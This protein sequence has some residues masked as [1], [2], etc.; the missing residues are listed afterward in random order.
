M[1]DLI[2]Y[3]G[4]IYTLAGKECVSALAVTG[5]RIEA[6]GNDREVLALADDRTRCI[7]LKGK[8][9]LPGFTDT[10]CHA[11]YAGLAKRQIPLNGVRSVEEIIQRGRDFIEKYQVPEGTWLVAGGFDHNHFD[12]PRLPQAADLDRI[13]TRH[14]I[15]LERIC[16]H[17]G[18]INTLAL[19]QTGFDREITFE[20]G[21][22]VEKDAQGRPTGVIVET[23]L[24]LI[25]TRIPKP[26]KYT[27]KE[28]FRAAFEEAN[29]YGVTGMHT[30][31]VPG[32]SLQTV[33]DALKDLEEEGRMTVRVWEEVE[34]P[35]IPELKEFLATGLRTGSGNRFFKIGNIKLISDGSLGART[36][37]LQAPYSDDPE[38]CG[39]RVYTQEELDEVV[40]TAHEAGMQVACHAIGDGAIQ[41]CAAALQRAY[42]S[43][44]KDLRNRIVH[45][46]F[47]NEKILDTMAAGR[48]CADIQPAFL[49]SDLPI[50]HERMGERDQ[51]GYAWKSLADKNLILGGGS[52]CPVETFNP[53]WG[54]HCAVNRTDAGGQPEGGWHPQQKLTV[55]EAVRLYTTGGAKLSLE[56]DCK[57]TLEP[58]KFADFAV[59]DQDIFS[60][61]PDR[62]C[63][64]KNTMTVMDGRIVYQID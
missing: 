4:R 2:F 26:D 5:Y 59:L 29:T 1:A 43:D 36:A 53:I 25:K 63:E 49:A 32:S 27:V 22:G 11:Y 40:L 44:G 50:I 12:E 45:C 24:D 28:A 56:E 58:G 48:I 15:L 42:E 19:S 55:E 23:A 41:Q 60:V 7:D 10:H 31:D 64:I 39:V 17:I 37:F 57:G 35:R 33:L 51:G 3:N 54:I 21:G 46:Q 18:S 20:G 16:G 38:N 30:D 9:V 14:P 13:S 8:C 62:I 34:A 52:D 6:V 47:V 61:S